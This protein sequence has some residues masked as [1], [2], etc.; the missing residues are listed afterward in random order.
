MQLRSKNSRIALLALGTSLSCGPALS[1]GILGQ[2]NFNGTPIQFF[3]A[4]PPVVAPLAPGSNL[5]PNFPVPVGLDKLPNKLWMSGT[6][7]VSNG[8]NTNVLQTLLDRKSAYVFNAAT[9]NTVGYD[10]GPA[11]LNVYCTYSAAKTLVDH[12]PSQNFA[13]PQ[14]VS[15]GLKE[16]FFSQTMEQES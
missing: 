4:L 5:F 16:I 8:L 15:F 7:N 12:Y 6:T 1:Q 14:S 9:S 2:D 13:T 3:N 11:H 10:L